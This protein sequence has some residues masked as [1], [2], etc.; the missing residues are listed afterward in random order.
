MIT[1]TVP[2]IRT[3]GSHISNDDIRVYR[4]RFV[5]GCIDA[6]VLPGRQNRL[7]K[8]AVVIS[9]GRSNEFHKHS[10]DLDHCSVSLVPSK[11][12]RPCAREAHFMN[13]N[14][15]LSDIHAR[16]LCIEIGE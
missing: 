11:S 4:L 10:N 2:I 5:T 13:S 3:E 15:G 8:I 16:K 9:R 14:N 7:T 6:F 12:S 1:S